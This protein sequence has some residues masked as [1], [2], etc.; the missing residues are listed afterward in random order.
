MKSVREQSNFHAYDTLLTL[1][2]WRH[3]LKCQAE[4]CKARAPTTSLIPAGC[5]TGKR[6]FNASVTPWDTSG[7]RQS[8]SIERSATVLLL[9]L[10][11]LKNRK[12]SSLNGTDGKSTLKY[13][14]YRKLRTYIMKKAYIT[15]AS[16]GTMIIDCTPPTEYRFNSMKKLEQRAD[17][18]TAKIRK[19]MIYKF[20]RLFGVGVWQNRIYD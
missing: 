17:R 4:E 18:N 15:V 3:T 12:E 1:E 8:K 10:P 6:W 9:G 19:G 13:K 7:E 5:T 16:N 2:C 20:C 14:V 11:P